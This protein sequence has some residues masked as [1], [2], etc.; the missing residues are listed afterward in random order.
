MYILISPISISHEFPIRLFL[1]SS[2]IPRRQERKISVTIRFQEF[3]KGAPEGVT[4]FDSRRKKGD[5]RGSLQCK[6][7]R[8]L[9]TNAYDSLKSDTLR[10]GRAGGL[11]VFLL[12]RLNCSRDR[13]PRVFCQ[14]LPYK[15]ALARQHQ[16]D[17]TR[18]DLNTTPRCFRTCR[19]TDFH[20][21]S[22]I[23]ERAIFHATEE[24][25]CPST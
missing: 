3:P 19:V 11:H 16:R 8:L 9:K 12:T 14:P 23:S 18:R 6:Q 4:V 17:A 15:P 7:L 25:K 20:P 5:Y 22:L 13:S 21:A 10:Y 24:R 2:S 1:N